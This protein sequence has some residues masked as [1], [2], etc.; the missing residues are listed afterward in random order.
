M[1]FLLKNNNNSGGLVMVMVDYLTFTFRLTQ[2]KAGDNILTKY[3]YTVEIYL[4][5]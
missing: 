4:S 2:Y 1:L 5:R 3:V